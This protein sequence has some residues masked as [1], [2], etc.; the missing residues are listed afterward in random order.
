MGGGECD[1]V[2]IGNAAVYVYVLALVYC[3]AVLCTVMCWVAFVCAVPSM[4]VLVVVHGA[5]QL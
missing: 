2:G 4:V 5:K 3:G 1:R